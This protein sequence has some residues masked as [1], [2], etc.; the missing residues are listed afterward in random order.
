MGYI[1]NIFLEKGILHFSGKLNT[2]I[3]PVINFGLVK[4][5]L[6]NIYT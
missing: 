2:V 3:D 5:M 6:K 4:C 1:T